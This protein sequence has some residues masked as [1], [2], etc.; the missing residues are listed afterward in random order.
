MFL[1]AACTQPA[2]A[3]VTEVVTKIRF[4]PALEK[5]K[6]QAGTAKLQFAQIPI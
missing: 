2:D 6:E 5:N 4:Y 3:T 1:D